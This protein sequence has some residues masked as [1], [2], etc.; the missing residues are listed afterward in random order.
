M[1]ENRSLWSAGSFTGS[2]PIHPDTLK[3]NMDIKK[4]LKHWFCFISW[5]RSVG[6]WTQR[7]NKCW[8]GFRGVHILPFCYSHTSR[9]LT[10]LVQQEVVR[11]CLWR[12]G[13][14]SWSTWCLRLQS[15]CGEMSTTNMESLSWGKKC[16]NFL[17]C[18]VG[19]ELLHLSNSLAQEK[20]ILTSQKRCYFVVCTC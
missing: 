9:P 16:W 13:H 19:T 14:Q 5:T 18:P 17:L 8:L 6:S 4:R 7:L 10:S 12:G 11:I 3:F 20:I 15:Q 1:K 2:W